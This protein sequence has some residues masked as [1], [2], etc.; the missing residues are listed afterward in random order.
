GRGG[1]DLIDGDKWLNVRISVRDRNDP[2]VELR[3]VDSMEDLIP[4]MLSGAINPGQLQIVRELKESTG[5][6]YDTAM[7]RDVRANY[8]VATADDGTTT[9][10]H[11]VLGGEGSDRLTGIERLQFADQAVDLP[12]GNAN[13]GPV[14]QLAI[15]EAASNV[16]DT[17]PAVGQVLR[18]SIDGV[19]DANNVNATNPSGAVTGP[20]TY[21]WQ[22][23]LDPGTGIFS[24]LTTI[25][26]GGSV[27]C[28]RR[29]LT[30]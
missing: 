5:F 9:V 8:T 11:N 15:A 14:G 2:S 27:W 25:A 30:Q 1:D 24:D 29:D 12:G 7:Y 10:T 26:A 28:P 17:T 22:V 16:V 20:V 21:V 23:E 18:V 13:A 4:D 3:S 19:T 6:N